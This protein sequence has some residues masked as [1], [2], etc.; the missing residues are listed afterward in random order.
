M[1]SHHQAEQPARAPLDELREALEHALHQA[2][3]EFDQELLRVGLTR[4]GHRVCGWSQLAQH[5]KAQGGP[6]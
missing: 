5:A 2:Q 6:S 3:R 4:D 1:N